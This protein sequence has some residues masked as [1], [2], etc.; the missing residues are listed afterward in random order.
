MVLPEKRWRGINTLDEKAR[1]L[2]VRPFWDALHTHWGSDAHFVAYHFRDSG[3]TRPVR[4]NKACLPYIRAVSGLEIMTNV[5]ALDYDLPG[6]QSWGDVGEDALSDFL[7]HLEL[8]AEHEPLCWQWTY[9][10]TTK[11]GARLIYLLEEPV[12]VEVA[13]EHHRWLT[14]QLRIGGVSIDDIDALGVMS[15]GEYAKSLYP[16]SDWTRCFRLPKVVRDNECSWES[17]FFLELEQR[18]ARLALDKLGRIERKGSAAVKGVE[19][20]AEPKPGVTESLKLLSYFN[21]ETGRLN[22]SDWLREAKRRLQG[23]ACYDCLFRHATLAKEGSRETTLM[24]F[25][26]EAVSL[27]YGMFKGGSQLT[28][29]AHIYALFL[30][31]VQQLE[32]DSGTPD[33][34]DSLWRHVGY[35]WQNEEAKWAKRA[36]EKQQREIDALQKLNAIVEG[37]QRWCD[38]IELRGSEE[39]AKEFAMRHL[40]AATERSCYVMRP[41]GWYD[42]MGT[43]AS[44]L[45]PRIRTLGMDDLIQIQIPTASGKGYRTPSAQELINEYGTPVKTVVGVPGTGED[46]ARIESIDG[47]RAVLI[48]PLYQLRT[49]LVPTFDAEIDQWLHEFFGEHYELGMVW[50]AFALRPDLGPICGISIQGGAGI[51]KKLWATG[52]FE[53]FVG[54][55][56]ASAEDLVSN[57]QPGLLTSPFLLIDEGWPSY[58][59]AGGKHPADMYR[60]LTGGGSRCVNVKFR[61]PIEVRNPVRV[62]FTANNF[63]VVSLLAGHRDLSPED[64]A[65]LAVRLLHLDLGRR[66]EFYLRA[67]GGIKHTRGW[68][69]G[70]GGEPSSFRL[71]RHFL[72]NMELRVG[73]TPVGSRLL[74][75]GNMAQHTEVAH[76]MRTR[77]GSAPIV[78]EALVRMLDV[79][80]RK[81][82]GLHIYKGN[83]FVLISEVLTFVRQHMKGQ[84]KI[85]SNQLTSVLTSLQTRTLEPLTLPGREILGTKRWYELDV[86]ELQRFAQEQGWRCEQLDRLAMVARARQR[87]RLRSLEET[88]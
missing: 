13:E 22:Q 3:Q 62:I 72:W 74:V 46:R 26:G 20:F 47:P 34:T 6:H 69:K 4:V 58:T 73:N 77:S 33:W 36:A 52:L 44:L 37:M 17:E 82:P 19:P 78:I 11:H 15:N 23:R 28:T 43:P 31:P 51:G 83:L 54:G 8:C 49:D 1:P 41:D 66:G 87:M 55:H 2:E 68:V 9:F 61:A 14:Q 21:E 67:R 81:F 7:R 57:F 10:H 63:D 50:C 27:L 35:C 80:A 56:A 32:P 29:P 60:E 12:D 38:A 71:A 39:E 59:L 18:D 25:V 88:L 85:S 48:K 86:E 45:V 79:K 5:L 16:T 42:Q 75:E 84:A 70:D 40:I 64:R 53:C 65:A 24:S 30:D 76:R